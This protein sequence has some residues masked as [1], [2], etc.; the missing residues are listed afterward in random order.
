MYLTQRRV[1][2]MAGTGVV[3]L[4]L[5]SPGGRRFVRGTLR[6]LVSIGRV[7]AG[8]QI[9][10]QVLDEETGEPVQAAAVS[11][12][13]TTIGVS[14]GPDGSFTVDLPRDAQTVVVRRIGYQAQSIP[15][16]EVSNRMDVRL[17]RDVLRL[18]SRVVAGERDRAAPSAPANMPA[19]EEKSLDVAYQRTDALERLGAAKVARAVTTGAATSEPFVRDASLAEAARMIIRTGNASV[20]VQSVDTAIVQVRSLATAMGGFVANNSIEGGRQ[21]LRSA[22]LEVRVPSNAF[23]R[24]LA[25]LAP[26][27]RVESVNVGAQDVGEEYVDL[28]ARIANDHRLEQR[29]IELIANRTGK[30]K[31]VLD[32]ERELA[33]VREEIERYEGRMRYLSSHAELSTLTINVHEP[34][35]ITAQVGTNPLVL[36]ARQA[37]RNFVGLIAWFIA[38]SGV[39]VPVGV[40]GLVTWWLARGRVLKTADVRR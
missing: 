14:T 32:V 10:G 27:G 35:P 17:K 40:V 8:G 19:L 39:L 37:W 26:L 12:P 6:P 25:G 33:R 3:I 7:S 34:V 16:A 29:L 4:T 20:E 18:E 5:L 24:L 11:V 22:S 13:G 23:D 9:T 2:V 31:D 21:A 1:A 36:A 30:L 15:S 28:Q 38:A